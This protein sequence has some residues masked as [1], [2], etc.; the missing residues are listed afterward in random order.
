MGNFT[1]KRQL[2]PELTQSQLDIIKQIVKKSD[3]E[4]RKWY[5]DFYKFAEGKQISESD[6][7]KYYQDL[8]PYRGDTDD[9]CKLVFK[10]KNNSLSLLL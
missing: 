9:F 4:I 3:N 10:S 5:N 7:T 8:L 2:D 1:S 6:F